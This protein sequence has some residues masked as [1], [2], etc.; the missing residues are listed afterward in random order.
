MIVTICGSYRYLSTMMDVYTI[1]T[2][3]G[4][5]VF[6][7]AINCLSCLN[8]SASFLKRVHSVK[9][10]SSDA[11]YIVDT[12]LKTMHIGKDTSEDIFFAET[13]GKKVIYVSKED[14]I[15][16][17]LKYIQSIKAK[18]EDKDHGRETE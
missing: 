9:I 16:Q 14:D 15:L 3:Y 10:A 4:H 6:L 17:L 1:L 5:L 13:I 18:K 12:D 11:V 2:H 8:T 7:P